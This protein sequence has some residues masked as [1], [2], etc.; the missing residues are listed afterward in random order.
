M[1]FYRL[2]RR[3]NV[4]FGSAGF[5]WFTA[6]KDA[7]A[8]MSAWIKENG[9]DRALGTAIATIDITPTKKKLL[10]FLNEFASHADNG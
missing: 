8:A 6:R 5:E 7:E 2:H 3:D 10:A 1:Q 9:E 4:D